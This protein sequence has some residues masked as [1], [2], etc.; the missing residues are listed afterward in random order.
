SG[1][2]H[3][4]NQSKARAVWGNKAAISHSETLQKSAR[5]FWQTFENESEQIE[6]AGNPYFTCSVSTSRYRLSARLL[7]CKIANNR[8]LKFLVAIGM[9]HAHH[10]GNHYAEPNNL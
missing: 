8:Q 1:T 7:L 6:C 9:N 4:F 3:I 2:G 5:D 10:Q